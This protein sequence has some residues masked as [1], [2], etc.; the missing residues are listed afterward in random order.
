MRKINPKKYAEALYEATKGLP[1]KTIKPE[2]DNFFALVLKKKGFKLLDKIIAE[3]AACC[4]RA[5]GVVAAEL[6]TRQ[7]LTP[8]ARKDIEELI[9]KMEKAKKINLT[10]VTDESVIGGIVLKLSDKVFDASLKTKL[11]LLR[12]KLEA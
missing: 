6:T 4:D 12:E 9:K 2:L 10:E 5:D 7:S 3:F 1:E 11:E 8:A